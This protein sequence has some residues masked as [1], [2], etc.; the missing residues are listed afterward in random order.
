LKIGFDASV[1]FSSAG[2]TR[3]YAT[4]LLGA[5]L[6]L[7]PD[8]TYLLYSRS[9][10]QADELRRRWPDARVRAVALPG[11]PNAWR[12]QVRLPMRLRK[13][14]VD[15]YHSLGYFLPLR[16]RGPKVVTIHDLNMYLNWRSWLRS[17]RLLNWAD[18]VIETPFAA[19]AAA[20]IITDSLYSKESICRLLRVDPDHVAAIHLAPDPY[21]DD[22]PTP[23]EEAEARIVAGGRRYVLYVGVLSPQKNLGTLIRAFAASRL[24][25]EGVSLVL[26]GADRSRH[27]TELRAIAAGAGVGERL[28]L[29]GFVSRAVLRALYHGALAVVLPS[30]GEG[31]GLPLVEAMAAG[32]PVFAANR[33]SLPEVV[34]D[35]GCVFEPDDVHGLGRLLGRVGTD[36]GFRERLAAKSNARRR[37]FSWRA[38]AEATARVYEQVVGERVPT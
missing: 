12:L 22:P 28:V 27:S 23:D 26:A 8:W 38:A 11:A 3:T 29:P 10:E 7:R 34:G 20:R 16:W 37:A 5:M 18:M 35:A 4:Q 36:D 19:R 31:F 13:D 25:V 21:F 24:S 1:I 15:L 33:Q 9:P 32:S 2:G 14:G 17:R 6:E 30:H